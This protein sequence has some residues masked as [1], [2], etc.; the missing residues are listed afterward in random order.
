[1]TQVVRKGWVNRLDEVELDIQ[2]KQ[3][4]A[5]LERENDLLKSLIARYSNSP[6]GSLAARRSSR[7]IASL[8]K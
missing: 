1:M 3:L 8:F 5:T 7:W 6:S 4:I 2:L